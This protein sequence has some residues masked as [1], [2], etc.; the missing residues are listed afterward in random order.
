M[1][2]RATPTAGTIPVV[3]ER[4]P[5]TAAPAGQPSLP[6]PRPT[7]RSLPA[8]E[9]TFVGRVGELE[10]LGALT[11]AGHIVSV[12]GPGGIGK[13]RLVV[14]MASRG[15]H[16]TV[17]VDASETR[18]VEALCAAT[19]AALDARLTGAKDEDLLGSVARLLRGRRPDLLIL[20]NV[21]QVIGPAAV[22]LD[23]WLQAAPEV[24]FVATSREPVGLPQEVVLRPDPLGLDARGLEIG[25]S[26]GA[27]LFV[28]RAVEARPRLR[29]ETLEP[30]LVD[31]IVARLEGLPLAIELA[32][33]RLRACELPEL[34]EA[35]ERT[36]AVLTDRT[37]DRPARHSTVH[38][39]VESSW[40]LLDPNERT[41]LAQLGA[42]HG[43][44]DMAAARAVTVPPAGAS[45]AWLED[46]VDSLCA[47]SLL[48]A[49]A[50]DGVTR[51]RSTE[52]VSEHARAKLRAGDGD[53]VRARHAAHY[54]SVLSDAA[55]ASA[56]R[57][58]AEGLATLR[59]ERDNALAAH[60]WCR[61]RP[62]DDND[63]A[64]WALEIALAMEPWHSRRGPVTLRRTL[65]GG[66][67]EDD[68]ISRVPRELVAEAR[69]AHGAVL[70]ELG[71]GAGSVR[72]RSA[73]A[74]LARDLGDLAL[75][76]HAVAA[77]AR[78][79]L[80]TGRLDEAIERLEVAMT[81]LGDAGDERSA[82]AAR[83]HLANAL[84]LR[85]DL[86]GA[87][88]AYHAA[89]AVLDTE[90]DERERALAVGNLASLEH[91]LGELDVARERCMEAV[92]LHR[93]LEDRHHEGCYLTNLGTMELERGDI[94]RARRRLTEAGSLL[95]ATGNRRWE[96]I[97]AGSVA[98]C[99]EAEGDSA[100]ALLGLREA[101]AVHREV[102]NVYHEGLTL[103]WIGRVLADGGDTHA[104]RRSVDAGR[105]KLE[106]VG[107]LVLIDV[108]A[109][110]A[111]H[112][113]VAAG[114]LS[115][116]RSAQ[117]ALARR[118]TSRRSSEVRMA[119]ARLDAL[120]G[121][122]ELSSAAS[123]TSLEVAAD[124]RW[125]GLPGERVDLSTRRALRLVLAALVERHEDEP[126]TALGVASLLEAGWPG[127]KMGHEAGVA[128]V[129]T[130][131]ASLRR[132]GLR[133][134][135]V[136]RDDGYLVDPQVRILRKP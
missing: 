95:R 69:I 130:A 29:R 68:R 11:A 93:D 113:D 2:F 59:R 16:D 114:N 20:D 70:L 107:E 117:K 46:A 35:L 88:S 133:D 78:T 62:P 74:R 34:V 57:R 76:G 82:A 112:V 102:G 45:E 99:S 9:T 108:A 79:A 33:A 30:M 111:A 54:A 43:G 106:A 127:E 50:G 122:P 14:E 51:Y 42:F 26:D 136:R 132:M 124:A 47:R 90:H 77:L 23:R 120:L 75:E 64:R 22:A 53:A 86:E 4:T 118:G 24:A 67:L 126:G 110:C 3:R 128:R 121:D 72:E 15:G 44:F 6:P 115:G 65:L 58:G 40:E 92:R 37:G 31:R 105:E 101:L 119:R 10:R 36:F 32:A 8:F 91:E 71:D 129:Y 89:I 12:V 18:S 56:G 100:G 80:H 98:L 131:V 94:G 60:A 73:A 125:F 1:C 84:T 87:R 52:I 104:A 41:V 109:A 103:C 97:A 85:G 27:Q 19:A 5:S 25:G 38:A 63:A 116:A 28:D 21:E 13:T 81:L 135:L 49:E 134:V 48:R 83:S 96:G 17:F 7:S 61:G 66:A 123:Q 55:R 39:L